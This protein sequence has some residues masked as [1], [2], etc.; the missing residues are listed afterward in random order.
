MLHLRI[1]NKAKH[2]FIQFESVSSSVQEKSSLQPQKC[3]PARRRINNKAFTSFK[4]LY[5]NNQTLRTKFR[6]ILH[7]RG[8]LTMEITVLVTCT[9]FKSP[10]MT[11][12]TNPQFIIRQYASFGLNNRERKKIVFSIVDGHGKLYK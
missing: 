9:S 10:E 6:I 11:T 3:I 2:V 4:H 5:I 12:L 8:K 7:T 1:L